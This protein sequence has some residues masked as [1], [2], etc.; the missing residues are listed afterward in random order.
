MASPS[1]LATALLH[2]PIQ[3]ESR[4]LIPIEGRVAMA[5]GM[6]RYH[7]P[8]RALKIDGAIF[9]RMLLM[10]VSIGWPLMLTARLASGISLLPAVLNILSLT[11]FM[12]GLV[13]LG[14]VLVRWLTFKSAAT[15]PR[16]WATGVLYLGLLTTAIVA[17]AYTGPI[18]DYLVRQSNPMVLWVALIGSRILGVCLAIYYYFYLL[19]RKQATQAQARLL[20]LEAAGREAEIER[21]RAQIN[22]HFLF[23]SLT[24]ISNRSSDPR[25]VESLTLKLAD[26]LRYNLAHLEGL[27]PFHEEL[28]AMENYLQI[29]QMRF[30]SNL[31][32]NWEVPPA[33]RAALVPQP[34]LL[35]MLENAIK[36][37]FETSAG[38]LRIGIKVTVQ[39]NELR[40]VVENSGRWIEPVTPALRGTQIGLSNLKRRLELY[41]QGR[42]H[43]VQ[44][45]L[46]EAVRI[47][48]TLP[49]DAAS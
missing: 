38:V 3:P 27:A 31:V 18:Q 30:G 29:E 20:A 34:L 36:Y 4:F 2:P 16:R 41:Y 24:A 12:S 6:M 1:L 48:L 17:H 25:S 44:E 11:L 35:P 45:S 13:L 40:A 10:M 46:P 7:D 37:G 49:L 22:P 42:A 39:G 14:I 23:N 21:L 28:K 19:Q 9:L 32:I 33:A 15:G 8:G 47:T 26:V 5:S 43:W